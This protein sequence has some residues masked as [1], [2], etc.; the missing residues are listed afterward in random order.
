[1]RKDTEGP[2][3]GPSARGGEGEVS[4]RPAITFHIRIR[5][6][7]EAARRN[8]ADSYAASPS[9]RSR[10]DFGCAPTAAAAGSPSLKRIMVGIDITP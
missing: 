4:K 10:A 3:S 7:T 8:S 6:R 1:L 9:E 2:E 5:L